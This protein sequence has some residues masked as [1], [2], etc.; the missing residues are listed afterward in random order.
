MNFRKLLTTVKQSLIKKLNLK[1][2]LMD[3]NQVQHKSQTV[4]IISDDQIISFKDF[5]HI[6]ISNDANLYLF[7]IGDETFEVLN[8]RLFK[9]AYEKIADAKVS[10]LTWNAHVPVIDIRTEEIRQVEDVPF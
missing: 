4:T 10:I 7:Y 6:P 9:I 1:S 2:P 8:E 3:F 5:A